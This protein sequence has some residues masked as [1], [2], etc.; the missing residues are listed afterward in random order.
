LKTRRMMLQNTFALAA[1]ASGL[2]AYW[3]RAMS[4]ASA[5][6]ASSF[7]I[8]SGVAG[9]EISVQRVCGGR[10]HAVPVIYVHGSTF[11]S[12]LAINWDFDQRQSW[13]DDLVAAGHDV[14]TFDFLGYGA[15]DRYAEMSSPAVAGPLGRCD[16]ASQQIGA[17]VEHVRSETHSARVCLVAH[18]WGTIAA[19]RF[20]TEH[21]DFVDRLV[22]F[23]PIVQRERKGLPNP[24]SLPG[25]MA[26]S[27][28]AQWKRF[29][30][31]VPSGEAALI[32]HQMF[33]PWGAA[34]LATDRAAADRTPPAVAI[35]MGPQADIAAAWQG[36]LGYDPRLIHAPVTILRGEWDSLC[37][38]EDSA[39]LRAHLSRCPSVQD[40]E[41][42][43]G[44]HLMLLES[45]RERLWA[46][47]RAA[48]AARTSAA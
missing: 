38:D 17:L 28:D 43:K 39:W 36:V 26:Q 3:T 18:S 10:E 40:V 30:E 37:T 46:A 24:A 8:H 4:A 2:D 48:L 5:P 21:P 22:L 32:T 9:L 1:L 12:A 33:D 41:L 23:G 13:R 45:G 15:S 34:Y 16:V 11:P 7:R 14:W 27:R 42:S 35:P 20:A 25:W 47:A 6:A 29:I 44:T 19:G 31:D